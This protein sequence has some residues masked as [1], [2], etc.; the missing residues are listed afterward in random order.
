[1]KNSSPDKKAIESFLSNLKKVKGELCSLEKE[2]FT[3]LICEGCDFY[4]S[5]KEVLECGAF[6]ILKSL[7]SEGI[8]TKDMLE[9][10]KKKF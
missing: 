10:L 9:K 5:E 4:S 1:M 3:I 8:V 7:I 2:N 6:K